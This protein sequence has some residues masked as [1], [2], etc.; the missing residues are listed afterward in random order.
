MEPDERLLLSSSGGGSDAG[1]G[2][3]LRARHRHRRARARS[4]VGRGRREGLR[5]RGR[6]H[7]VLRQ[8]RHALCHRTRQ[9]AR[10]R[11]AV[12][13]DHP[14]PV[15]RAG[16]VQTPFPLRGAGQLARPHR[17]AAGEQ[18]LSHPDRDAVG[19]AVEGRARPRRPAAGLER[20]AR[21]ATPVRPA[22]VAAPPAD[23]GLRDGPFG[24]RRHL[25]G[26]PGSRGAGRETQDGG[27]GR[28]RRNRRNGRGGQGD[29]DRRAEGQAGRIQHPPSRGD[30]TRASRLS[31][32][33]TASPTPSRRR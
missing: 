26:Q 28:D 17:A 9:D 18:R 22:M 21:P 16:R 14:R 24:V 8:R 10:V 25:R 3:F 15:R 20:G 6:Q 12:G 1:A 5:Q 7:V 27:A 32:A 19:R 13:R 30:R 2:A 11:G 33:S 29:R 4:P 31:S 23:H